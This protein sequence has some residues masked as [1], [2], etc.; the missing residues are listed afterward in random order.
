MWLCNSN[1]VAVPGPASSDEMISRHTENPRDF[2]RIK[3]TA[4]TVDLK[5]ECPSYFV[6]VSESVVGMLIQPKWD[7][8]TNKCGMVAT[9]DGP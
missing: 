1:A 4:A 3:T 8:G 6:A 2:S 7:R 5:F 9:L